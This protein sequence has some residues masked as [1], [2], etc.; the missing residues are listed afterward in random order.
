MT[1]A[2]TRSSV[3][4]VDPERSREQAASGR[5]LRCARYVRSWGKPGGL[6]GREAI[7]VVNG[8]P[9]CYIHA[10]AQAR[11]DSAA[12]PRNTA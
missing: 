9:R 2:T 10:P 6:C 1:D 12:R 4:A 7:A 8:V 11:R 5:G 3:S